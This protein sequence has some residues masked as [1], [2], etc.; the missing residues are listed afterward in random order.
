MSCK[1]RRYFHRVVLRNGGRSKG[2]RGLCGLAK[3]KWSFVAFGHCILWRR[4]TRHSVRRRD[5]I[6][7]LLHYDNAKRDESQRHQC[8]KDNNDDAHR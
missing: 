6:S 4:H 3:V 1:S 2:C 5:G 7:T 8:R